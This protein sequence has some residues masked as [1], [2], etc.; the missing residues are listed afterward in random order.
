MTQ[1]L[2][3]V[4]LLAPEASG[5]FSTPEPVDLIQGALVLGFR[6]IQNTAPHLEVVMDDESSA[7]ISTRWF[8]LGSKLGA[9]IPY[10]IVRHVGVDCIGYQHIHCFEILPP[11]ESYAAPEP[12]AVE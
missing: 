10:V 3:H 7:P 1:K 6:V 9:E 4:R 8:V 5:G 11:E 2:Y 12:L